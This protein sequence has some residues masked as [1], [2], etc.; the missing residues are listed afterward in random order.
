MKISQIHLLTA[1]AI[2]MTGS[3]IPATARPM[4]DG[5]R[6]FG[7]QLR[8]ADRNH[9]GQTSRPELVSYR[10]TQWTRFDR[11]GDGYFSRDDLPGFVRERWDG[12]KFVQLRRVY[13]RDGDGR[14]SRTEFVG[15]PTPAFDAADAN[16]DGLVSEAELRAMAA[17][18]RG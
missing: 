12:E 11:N 5:S 2:A 7:E 4:A 16:H 3:A 8:A 6:D 14:I 13:D 1:A 10:A 18:I 9:D 15:G 17:Q